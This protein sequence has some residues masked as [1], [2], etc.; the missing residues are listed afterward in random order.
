[1]GNPNASPSSKNLKKSA[2]DR[3]SVHHHLLWRLHMMHHA[4]LDY[5]LTTGLRFHPLEIVLSMALK[6]TVIAALG[7]PVAS[8]LAFE[9]ILNGMAMF[10]HANIK[11]PQS[12]FAETGLCPNCARQGQ[13]LPDSANFYYDDLQRFD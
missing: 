12:V 1:M 11:I 10:N 2:L 3:Q 6:L 4:D 8:V 9:V 13:T 5:D 7:P